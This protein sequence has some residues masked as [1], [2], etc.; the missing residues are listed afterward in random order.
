MN[1]QSG[2]AGS[3][4]PAVLR[5]SGPGAAQGNYPAGWGPRLGGGAR[6]SGH[7]TK[8]AKESDGG[9]D[10]TAAGTASGP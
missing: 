8:E 4:C 1:G 9:L 6:R 2:P 3:L 5:A 10:G 7:V